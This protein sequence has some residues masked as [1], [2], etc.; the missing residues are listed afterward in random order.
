M[1]QDNFQ[2]YDVT[3]DARM[4]LRDLQSILVSG[5]GAARRG[6]SGFTLTHVADV[7]RGKRVQTDFCLASIGYQGRV[8]TKRIILSHLSEK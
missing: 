4:I 5:A 2:L 6:Y 7:Y 3:A 1:F 8:A